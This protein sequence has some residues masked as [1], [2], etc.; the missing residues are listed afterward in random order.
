MASQLLNHQIEKYVIKW[1]GS[2]PPL[3]LEAEIQ[4]K[5]G[6]KIGIIHS[7]GFIEKKLHYLIMMIQ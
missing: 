2:G 6:Q 4:T 1:E 3:D 7:S 5:D